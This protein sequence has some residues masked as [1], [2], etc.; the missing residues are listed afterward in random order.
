M[1]NRR[2]ARHCVLG[3]SVSTPETPRK[4][5]DTLES[6]ES[7]GLGCPEFLGL[8]AETLNHNAVQIDHPKREILQI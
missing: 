4:S 7:L 5:L 6:P 3:F 2:D 1:N 8:T